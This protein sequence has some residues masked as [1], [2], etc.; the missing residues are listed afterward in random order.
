MLGILTKTCASEL[1]ESKLYDNNGFYKKFMS[2]LCSAEQEIVIESPFI[3]SRRLKMLMPHLQVQISHGVNVTINTRD[4][5]EHEGYLRS[6]AENGISLL[7]EIGAKVLYTGGHH[8]KLAIIDR[9]T[10]W[11][12]GHNILS[13]NDSCEVMRR[14]ASADLAQQMIEFS[15]ISGYLENNV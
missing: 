3:T 4:P 10:L 5:Q 7:Q 15:G 8:R 6:E 13:Q 9:K 11:E 2:D 1:L 12:G 14:T